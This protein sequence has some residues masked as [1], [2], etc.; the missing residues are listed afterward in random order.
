MLPPPPDGYRDRWSLLTRKYRQESTPMDQLEISGSMN[1]AIFHVCRERLGDFARFISTAPVE[2]DLEEIRKALGEDELTGYLISYG[3]D[4]DQT[5]AN[6]FPDKVGR[7][8]LD[9]TEYVKDH[10]LEL[11]ID[12]LIKSLITR[13]IPAYTESSGPSLITHSGLV[14]SLYPTMYNPRGWPYAAQMLYEL[15]AG[16]ATLGAAFLDRAW[17]SKPGLLSPHRD[18]S[19]D[20]LPY[21]V[22]CADAYDALQPE[23][24]LLW[25][26]RLWEDMTTRSWIAGNF[27]FFTGLP[28]RHFN[29]YWSSQ[30]KSIM[31]I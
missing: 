4:I 18:L 28:C 25:W 6:M 31:A 22:I 8:I 2:R 21:L 19:S 7:L 13:P 3:T 5:Y 30:P 24:G 1:D 12:S 26:D 27:R 10:R 16:N 9:G 11:R 20:E 23:D 29:T 15:E 17:E 14:G